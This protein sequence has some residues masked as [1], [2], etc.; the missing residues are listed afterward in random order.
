MPFG[1]MNPED[2][3]AKQ[4]AAPTALAVFRR[5]L[6]QLL[7][8]RKKALCTQTQDIPTRL[9]YAVVASARKG[10]GTRFERMVRRWSHSQKPG[11][12]PDTPD[13]PLRS[14]QCEFAEGTARVERIAWS[15]GQAEDLASTPTQLPKRA[16]LLHQPNELTICWQGAGDR[17]RK[18]NPEQKSTMRHER[19]SGGLHEREWHP[20]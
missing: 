2:P 5:M 12:R 10:L 18:Q 17:N 14:L 20:S 19:F 11:A 16:C 6:A 9:R 4:Q 1:W 15:A 13:T 7:V 3:Y 8:V